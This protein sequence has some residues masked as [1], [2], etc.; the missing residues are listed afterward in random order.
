M[1]ARRYKRGCHAAR[2]GIVRR[3]PA[4]PFR[5]RVG[6]TLQRSLGGVRSVLHCHR[7]EHGVPAIYRGRRFQD[8]LGLVH[9][10]GTFAAR[11]HGIPFRADNHRSELPKAVERLNP[12]DGHTV[13]VGQIQSVMLTQA[14]ADRL[15]IFIGPLF[16]K[17]SWLFVTLGVFLFGALAL[18][19]YYW[20]VLGRVSV[21]DSCI[22]ILRDGREEM[23]PLSQIV[24]LER[25]SGQVRLA[26]ADGRWLAFS[27]PIY[28][29]K[30][31]RLAK[32]LR[33]FNV[34]NSVCNVNVAPRSEDLE[35]SA[36]VQSAD[37]P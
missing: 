9:D 19:G 18:A 4:G 5:A 8:R 7:S 25:H 36:P 37:S 30:Q 23:C 15:G 27:W 34:L 20:S 26:L 16:D 3:F 22:R 14:T 12:H 24:L 17:I 29:R 28:V 11:I 32:A 6:S 1:G 35:A 13:R 31:D 2:N 33:L 21:Q 10:G